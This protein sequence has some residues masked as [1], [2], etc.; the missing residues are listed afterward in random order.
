M[1]EHPDCN[2]KTLLRTA[3]R[4]EL[5]L[6]FLLDFLRMQEG[7]QG[8]IARSNLI[9]VF[10]IF[11]VLRFR[12]FI[13]LCL[14]LVFR[15][16]L[17]IEKAYVRSRCRELFFQAFPANMQNQITNHIAVK[18]RHKKSKRRSVCQ[19]CSVMQHFPIQVGKLMRSSAKKKGERKHP[20]KHGIIE[21]VRAD[22]LRF[23]SGCIAH[24]CRIYRLNTVLFFSVQKVESL[25]LPFVHFLHHI[26]HG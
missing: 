4:T 23:L 24:D 9:I 5:V 16:F 14:F 7:K 3:V 15:L 19:L 8:R 17:F 10:H 13:P 2:K 6:F 26:L 11:P 1:Q 20:A 25:G 22:F 21:K 12:F 18:F